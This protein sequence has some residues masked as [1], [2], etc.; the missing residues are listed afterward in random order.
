MMVVFSF[1]LRTFP[2]GTE[3]FVYVQGDLVYH[4]HIL[5]GRFEIKKE[6]RL[7]GLKA[8]VVTEVGPWHMFYV[9]GPLKTQFTCE[10][11]LTD[12]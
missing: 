1:I 9:P 10:Q 12:W 8:R 3:K 11:L 5:E 7:T 4:Q 6:S 2:A